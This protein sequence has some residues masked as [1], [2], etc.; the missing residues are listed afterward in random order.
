MRRSRSEHRNREQLD[1]TLSESRFLMALPL[2]QQS[3]SS[4]DHGS[5]Q[6]RECRICYHSQGELIAPCFCKGTMKYVH[7]KCLERWLRTS[8]GASRQTKLKCELC[9]FEYETSLRLASFKAVLAKF[10]RSMRRNKFQTLKT[11]IYFL[12]LYIFYIKA[13]SVTKMLWKV[14]RKRAAQ[15]RLAAFLYTFYFGT[16]I[17]ELFYLLHSEGKRIV[18]FARGSFFEICVLSRRR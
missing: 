6:G 4:F 17:F 13:I 9:Q 3:D 7:V 1:E 12:Y 8:F 5:R 15:S 16:I 2:S 18:R 10:F 11:V 14:W